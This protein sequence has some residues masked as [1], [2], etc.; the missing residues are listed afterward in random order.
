MGSEASVS[1]FTLGNQ[2]SQSG[3]CGVV[4]RKRYSVP[5]RYAG[6]MVKIKETLDHHLEIYDE[7]ECIAK[8]PVLTGKATTHIRMEHYDGLHTKEKG[9]KA[10]NVEDLATD[11]LH[12]HTPSP[13]VEK[14][15]LAAYAALEEGESV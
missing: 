9:Q 6:Q 3:L 2:R 10:K 5:Y 1:H 15:P 11:G 4:P 7:R 14:R 12:S 8:H 13:N